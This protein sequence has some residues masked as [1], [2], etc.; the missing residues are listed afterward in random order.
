MPFQIIF[1]KK[2][3]KQLEKLRNSNKKLLKKILQIIDNIEVV[4]YSSYFKF[5]R[6]KHDLSGFC[7]KR[8]DDKNRVLYFVND[9]KIVVVIISVLGIMM[10]KNHI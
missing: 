2:A 9:G 10:T 4:P 8:V 1:E 6:L 5:E 7:S 3:E